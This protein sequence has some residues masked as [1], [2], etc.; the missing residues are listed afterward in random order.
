PGADRPGL[1]R[2]IER[3]LRVLTAAHSLLLSPIVSRVAFLDIRA[4]I[5]LAVAAV[6][7]APV[8]VFAPNGTVVLLGIAAAILAFDP[9][10]RR[11]ALSLLHMPE[12]RLIAVMLVLGAVAALWSFDPLR[13]LFLALRL[14]LLMGFGIVVLAAAVTLSPGEARLARRGMTMGGVLLIALM[15]IETTSGAALSQFLRGM[16]ADQLD[17]A[18]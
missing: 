9:R 7:L 5:V 11:A 1:R 2:A 15:L 8:A 13:G 16:N 18:N 17:A 6:A 4:G 14:A 3:N 12:H 10:H